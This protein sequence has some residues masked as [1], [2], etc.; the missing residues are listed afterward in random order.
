MNRGE[1]VNEEAA[2]R[3]GSAAESGAVTGDRTGVGGISQGMG[4]RRSGQDR[5]FGVLAGVMIAL[6]LYLLVNSLV[7]PDTVADAPPRVDLVTPSD[8]DTVAVPLTIRLRS[9]APL[10]IQPGGW[11][12]NGYHL[13]VKIA[14]LELMAGPTDVRPF[15]SGEYLWEVPAVPS[16]PTTVRLFWADSAHRPVAAGASEVVSV[17]V[18]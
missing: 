1:G 9:E 3:T 16:G 6:A 11:G 7:Q 10:S 8:G 17:V 14:D 12:V 13:H 18:R 4:A 15:S 2:V 5:M